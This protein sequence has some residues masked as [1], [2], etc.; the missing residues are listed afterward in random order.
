M[1]LVKVKQKVLFCTQ[2][3]IELVHAIIYTSLRAPLP[4]T[5]WLP[6]F[7]TAASDAW[8][9]ISLKTWKRAASLLRNPCSHE[10][11]HDTM[12]YFTSPK[13][14][15]KGYKSECS[16]IFFL[17]FCY[18]WEVIGSFHQLQSSTV[19]AEL[20]WNYRH[21]GFLKFGFILVLGCVPSMYTT[22]LSRSQIHRA[23]NQRTLELLFGLG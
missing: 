1:S 23:P 2:A 20:E 14:F 21:H 17:F 10:K 15:R 6:V 9:H 19:R 11:G 4:G 16:V 13:A 18:S 12:M 7:P 22:L 5:E 3:F 8:Y